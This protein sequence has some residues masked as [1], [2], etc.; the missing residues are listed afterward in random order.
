MSG[1]AWVHIGDLHLD[2][3]DDWQGLD[4]LKAIVAR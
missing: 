1:I 2:E 4:R 3:A